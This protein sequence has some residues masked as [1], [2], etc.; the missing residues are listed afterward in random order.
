MVFF[1]ALTHTSGIAQTSFHFRHLGVENGLSQGSVY[2]I[3]KDSRGFMWLGTQDGINRFDGKNVDVYL[4]GA[5]GQSTNIQGIAEDTSG[6]LWIGSHQGLYKY[7]RKKNLCVK[8]VLKNGPPLTS[9]HLFNDKKKNIF[10]LSENGLSQIKGSVVK[11]LTKKITY[12]RSQVNN[13][14]AESSEGDF[15]FTDLHKGLK[16]YSVKSG[17]VYHYFSENPENLKGDP[18]TF[19][20][21]S[22]G[23]DGNIWLGHG[24]DLML[25]KYKTGE[26]QH[27][28]GDLVSG[29]HTIFDITEDANG[30][31]WIATEGDGIV[32][33]DPAQKKVIRRLK[34]END[35][36]NSLRFNEVSKIFIDENNDVF[37]STDPQG[38]DVISA[39]PSGFKYYTYGR[40]KQYALSAYS[41]RG[42]AED[43]DSTIWVGTELGG[44]NLLN[45]KTGKVSH[46]TSAQGLP[47]NSIRYL[48]KDPHDQIWVSTEHGLAFFSN[49]T[50]RFI[51]VPLPIVCEIT[52]MLY[53]DK[54]H[55]L[56]T[57]DKGLMLLDCKSKT[58]SNHSH[59]GMVGGYGSYMDQNTGLIY[60]S[61]RYRGI[62]VFKLNNKELVFKF[63]LMSVFHVMHMYSD[64]KYLWS[65]TD[66]GLVKLNIK[67]NKIEKVYGISDGLH[68]EFLYAILPDDNNLWLSTNRGLSRF[69]KRSERFEFIKEISPREYNSRS[70]LVTRAGDLYFGST[71]GL[72]VI[73]PKSLKL[74]TDPVGI[75]LTDIDYNHPKDFSD[76]WYIGEL[77]NITL[78]YAQNTITLKF[79]AVDY[80][81]GGINRYRYLLNGYDNDTIYSGTINQVRYAQL[82]AG[83]YEFTVQAS[84]VGGKWVSPF[85]KLT[86]I[87][88][89]PFWQTWWF[90]LALC[91]AIVI[92]TIFSVSKYLDARLYAQRLESNKKIELEKERSR[93]ARDMNDSLG[94]ELF[95]LKLLGQ[96]AL[97]QSSREDA[98]SYIQKIVD[99]SKGISEKISEVIWLTDSDQDNVESLWNYIRKN[100][101]IYL[102]P[103]GIYY[104]FDALPTERSVSI[105]GE[106]RHEIL[107][108]NRQLFFKLTKACDFPQ[109]KVIFQLQEN[110]LLI[111]LQNAD[112]DETE[113]SLFTHLER[114]QG[115][116]TFI[117]D[118]VTEVRIPLNV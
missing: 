108:F 28:S 103:S 78:P 19:T 75:H 26:I 33:F 74:R 47:G 51:P 70:A 104:R 11:L 48:L 56:L 105:S 43:K 79:S 94:S 27:F 18:K 35:T 73:H 54:G 38:I 89:P 83:K 101:H 115:K 17:K 60:V 67:K 107:H 50:N 116:F 82:P 93:I 4:S 44:I 12:D 91:L 58:I 5:S 85:K 15:W 113:K 57:T 34:H 87:I 66:R 21:I 39:V 13:F 55:L 80:R 8:A 1:L 2:H 7:I 92:I 23:R 71:T 20:S 98:N 111:T 40:D 46:Y 100:A 24:K 41:V 84:D 117:S 72:D 96:I 65:A 53:I 45:I 25:F 59:T 42:I 90:V 22:S 36:P 62:D 52:N 112:L 6:N 69:N 81:S 99:T 14:T 76:T 30:M 29:G 88:Q 77:P 109:C 97:S 64:G 106:R 9:V 118:Q 86:I 3:L 32:L 10:I 63:R 37:A 114:L 16:R 61:N 49:L 110:I 102:K 95:G 68:H 31:L